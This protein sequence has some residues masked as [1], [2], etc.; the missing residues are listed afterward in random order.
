MPSSRDATTNKS[1]SQIDEEEDLW[2]DFDFVSY[3]SESE[4]EDAEGSSSRK[5]LPLHQRFSSPADRVRH[6]PKWS[7]GQ[8]PWSRNSCALSVLWRSI[9]ITDRFR[10]LNENFEELEVPLPQHGPKTSCVP[11]LWIYGDP[12]LVHT[13]SEVSL[14]KLKKGKPQLKSESGK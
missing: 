7:D 4:S 3:E 6:G 2:D 13:M 14:N 11:Q 1:R 12:A 9:V 8:E 5:H 10:L